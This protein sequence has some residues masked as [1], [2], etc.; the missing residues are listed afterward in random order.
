MIKAQRIEDTVVFT[1]EE[2]DIGFHCGLTEHDIL[3]LQHNKELN[4]SVETA[5]KL[6]NQ[7]LGFRVVYIE[8][9]RL[10]KVKPSRS[11]D[12]G[13]RVQVDGR[14]EQ[15]DNLVDQAVGTIETLAEGQMA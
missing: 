7:M 3:R 10:F 11:P 6:Y 13:V 2:Q 12:K 9:G 15:M 4:L 5:I 8:D 14:K 1:D